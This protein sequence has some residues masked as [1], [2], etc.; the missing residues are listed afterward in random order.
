MRLWLNTGRL[1][2]PAVVCHPSWLTPKRVE[3]RVQTASSGGGK[4]LCINRWLET[5]ERLERLCRAPPAIRRFSI[6]LLVSQ[7]KTKNLQLRV[8]AS[9]CCLYSSHIKFLRRITKDKF[10]ASVPVWVDCHDRSMDHKPFSKHMYWLDLTR[11]PRPTGIYNFIKTGPPAWRC[12]FNWLHFFRTVKL[13]F[14]QQVFFIT[15][16]GK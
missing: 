3:L 16:H 15:Q 12:V 13:L 2:Q 6:S 9:T 7:S 8:K 4:G 1:Q 14:L 10:Y 11:Q 5:N